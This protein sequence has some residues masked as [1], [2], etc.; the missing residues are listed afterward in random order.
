MQRT[1]FGEKYNKKV[2]DSLIIADDLFQRL[3]PPNAG[4]HGRP[5][6]I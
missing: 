1:P 4:T 2:N 6:I 3:Y 5:V